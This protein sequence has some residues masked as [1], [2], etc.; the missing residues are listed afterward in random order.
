MQDVAG[1]TTGTRR[2]AGRHILRT[3][4][5]PPLEVAN[6][7]TRAASDSMFAELQ[8]A[9]VAAGLLEAMVNQHRTANTFRTAAMRK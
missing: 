1:E 5:L 3:Y 9:M 7:N 4:G 6:G 2:R 8:S